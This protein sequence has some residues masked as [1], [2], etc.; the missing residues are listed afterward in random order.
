MT[1]FSFAIIIRGVNAILIETTA[2]M[3]LAVAGGR[4]PW[5]SVNE[6]NTNAN[7]PTCPSADENIRFSFNPSL[8][9]L[10]KRNR[11]V[12]FTNSKINT[13]PITNKG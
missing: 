6:S 2:I 4:M 12:L 8:K 1:S 9:D 11:T 5:F 10:P 7:S 13:Q 3:R